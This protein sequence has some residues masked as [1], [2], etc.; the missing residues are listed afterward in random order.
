MRHSLLPLLL[1]S[2]IPAAV[3]AQVPDANK[4]TPAFEETGEPEGNDHTL[5]PRHLDPR[6]WNLKEPLLLDIARR[7][8]AGTA[9]LP[10]ARSFDRLYTRLFPF[11]QG[12]PGDWREKAMRAERALRP[13]QRGNIAS[14]SIINSTTL[15][16]ALIGPATYSIGSDQV[17]GRA[18]AIYVDP[19]NKNNIILGTADG[20]LW[21]T[22]DQGV[23]WA[24]LTAPIVRVASRGRSRKTLAATSR[25]VTRP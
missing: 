19:A 10:M 18:T 24:S 1:C 11:T 12:V 17:S 23:N 22:T 2:L 25:N 3:L 16:W 13:V 9:P 8:E 20:G 5:P 4:T 7:V 6:I 15:T 21:K 14:P